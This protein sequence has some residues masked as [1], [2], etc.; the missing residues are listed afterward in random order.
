MLIRRCFHC[1]PL[2][3]PGLLLV[4]PS[5][6]VLLVVHPGRSSENHSISTSR[7]SNV[8]RL[9]SLAQWVQPLLVQVDLLVVPWQPC[10]FSSYS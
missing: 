8:L 4:L 1:H 2:D 3:G 9:P 10:R 6:G 5:S 7:S